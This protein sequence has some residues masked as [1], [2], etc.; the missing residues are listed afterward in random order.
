MASLGCI[1]DSKCRTAVKLGRFGRCGYGTASPRNTWN[2]FSTT[3]PERF[4]ES[5]TLE[6]RNPNANFSNQF[7][8]LQQLGV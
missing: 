1:V 6:P 2:D 5:H 3:E 7:R 8:R 4:S